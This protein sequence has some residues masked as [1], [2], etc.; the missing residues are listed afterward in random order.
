MIH[1]RS[2]KLEMETILPI[3]QQ[4]VRESAKEGFCLE[5]KMYRRSRVDTDL[6]ILLYHDTPIVQEEGSSLG[7]HIATALKEYGMVKHMT[8]LEE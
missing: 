1:L 8:W 6:S 7:L 2:S 5:I 3:G 4:L